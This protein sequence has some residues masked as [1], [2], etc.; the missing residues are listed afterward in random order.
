[1]LVLQGP[2]GERKSTLLK[3]LAGEAYFSDS[4]FDISNKDSYI[5]IR[6]PWIYECAELTSL[7]K[8]AVEDVKAFLTSSSDNFRA[9]YERISKAH[10][11]QGIFVGSTEKETFLM[12]P[13]GS[14]RFW[15]VRVGTIQTSGFRSIVPQL[16]GE[17]MTALY[18]G[19]RWWLEKHEEA[20]RAEEAEQFTVE[21]PWVAAL[22][23]WFKTRRVKDATFTLAEAMQGLLVNQADYARMTM[24]ITNALKAVGCT[25]RRHIK[26]GHRA[27]VWVPPAHLSAPAP[28]TNVPPIS[29]AFPHTPANA[30]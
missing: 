30:K 16:I 24:P 21:D 11:R 14:R 25:S 18:A 12:D 19:E 2:Q 28:I 10:P 5:T 15:P 9:P 29:S 3:D 13:A 1:V 6:K 20:I 17:A 26:D 22:A 23:A 27:T 8:S 7:T 4:K